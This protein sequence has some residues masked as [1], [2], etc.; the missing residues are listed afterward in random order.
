MFEQ[1][2]HFSSI[3]GLHNSKRA[4]TA[5]ANHLNRIPANISKTSYQNRIIQVQEPDYLEA[6]SEWAKQIISISSLLRISNKKQYIDYI[7][8]RFYQYVRRP[9]LSIDK[10]DLQNV[11]WGSKL[12]PLHMIEMSNFV[13][14]RPNSIAENWEPSWF[15]Q[16]A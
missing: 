15:A 13:K 6:A 2:C 11:Y 7:N 1:K 9:Y 8:E 3:L 14:Y 16:I 5:G 4:A 12:Y 10:Q